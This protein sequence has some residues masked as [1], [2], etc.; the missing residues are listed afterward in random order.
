MHWVV[1][2]PLQVMLQ[3]PD[4]QL[5]VDPAPTV[6]VHEVPPHSTLEFAPVLPVQVEPAA[7]LNELIALE[8]SPKS[9]VALDGQAQLLPAHTLGEQ[10][11]SDESA[12][13]KPKR[14]VRSVMNG[15]PFDTE[16]KASSR[17][18]N[19]EAARR[20]WIDF[21]CYSR[22]VRTFPAS[23]HRWICLKKSSIDPKCADAA[24]RPRSYT[25]RLFEVSG[26]R[27]L[28]L[29]RMDPSRD[30]TGGTAIR[31]LVARIGKRQRQ[32][33]TAV[34]VNVPPGPV[35]VNRHEIPE[36]AVTPKPGAVRVTPSGHS[37]A[38]G[39][40]PQSA[41][42]VAAWRQFHSPVVVPGHTTDGGFICTVHVGGGVHA[43]VAVTVLEPPGPVAVN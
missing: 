8:R 40:A 13:A 42:H 26:D 16:M 15:I 11:T 3:V 35:A 25:K 10:P 22:R 37:R 38:T 41:V 32:V 34:V 18:P 14:A 33:A 30:A 20:E 24:A 1:H 28:S 27:A 9:Q 5:T 39:P 2:A 4:E 19:S 43:A 7:Q 6:T 36:G 12:S 17:A 29:R 21:E 23:A 31:A